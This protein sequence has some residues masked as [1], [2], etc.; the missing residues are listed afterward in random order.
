[1]SS[2]LLLVVVL[3]AALACTVACVAALRGRTCQ[4]RF[5]LPQQGQIRCMKCLRV[6]A[7]EATSHGEWRIARRAK[8]VGSG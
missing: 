4:H 7:I 6:F 1:M 5:G 2:P 3:T 8:A